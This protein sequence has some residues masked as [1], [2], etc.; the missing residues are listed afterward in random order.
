MR[1]RRPRGR[2][3]RRRHRWGKCRVSHAAAAEAAKGGGG[4][5]GGLLC[6]TVFA[7]HPPPPTPDVAGR[8]PVHL[9]A[10]AAATAAIVTTIRGDRPSLGG[11]GHA[12]T[13]GFDAPIG[14]HGHSHPRRL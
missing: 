7:R 1:P 3:R 6:A 14:G 2:D 12:L 13:G 10:A 8:A 4:V 11:D 5:G 9:P